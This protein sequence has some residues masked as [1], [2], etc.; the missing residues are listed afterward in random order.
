MSARVVFV[1]LL[2]G[3]GIAV[4]DEPAGKGSPDAK[5][6]AEKPAPIETG[7]AVFGGGCFWSMEAIFER[8]PGVK[9]VTS[10]FAGGVVPNPS[11]EQVCTSQTGHAEVI[12]VEYDPKATTYETLLK[13]FWMSHD[14]T[15]LNSQGDDEGPQYRSIILYEN[16][17]QKKTAQAS[18]RKLKAARTFKSPIVTQL[19]PLTAFYPAEPYHQDYYQNHFSEPYC[20]AV[21]E[22]KLYKLDTYLHPRTRKARKK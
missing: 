4:G 5:P 15:T 1:L 10:G 20:Q 17:D 6:K 19:V 13:F 22:P 8:V 7:S 3:G 2:V 18:Y 9:S 11:Y 12:R 14:P 21:I 16:D